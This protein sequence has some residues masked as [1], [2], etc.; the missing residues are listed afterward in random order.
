MIVHL[1]SFLFGGTRGGGKTDGVLGK[2]VIKEQRYGKHFNGKMFRRTTVS[3][4]D[5]IER[6]KEIY[7]PL[8]AKFNN[9]KLIWR[10]PNGGRVSFGYLENSKDAEN[11]QGKN[12]TD[13]WIE[14]VGQYA[15]PDPIDKLFGAMRSAHGVP[16]QMIQTGNPGGAGQFWIAEAYELIPFPLVPKLVTREVNGVTQKI[17][18]IP[19]RIQ[20]NKIL[21]TSDPG[22]IERLH[23]VGSAALVK[24]WLEGDWGAV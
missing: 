1:K 6:S 21:L 9:Q 14:E 22:Y 12:L 2:W 19:S 5:A 10:L 3:A 20:D 16:I 15:M 17:A 18:V 13:V 23:F 4:E 8:G 7:E 11:E 24:A